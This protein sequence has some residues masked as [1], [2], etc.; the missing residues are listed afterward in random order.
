MPAPFFRR[1]MMKFVPSGTRSE[2]M[3]HR[4]NRVCPVESAGSLDNRLRRWVQNPRTILKP[5]IREGMTVVDVGCG[6][7]FFTIEVADMVGKPGT[8]IACD[9]QDGMLK[10]LR[11][12]IQGTEL[13]QRI[14]L[15]RSKDGSIGVSA[16]ADF[17]LAFYMVH[18]V[19]DQDRFLAE[20]KSM[21]KP[22][23]QLLIVEPK[24][25][26]VSKQAFDQTMR[27]AEAMGFR[28]VAEPRIFFS[29]SAVLK[30]N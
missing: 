19:P 4:N 16:E 2:N 29:R 28:V 10:K 15:H 21:L 18:E 17:V 22:S 9:I 23:G 27:K 7:G 13:D 3:I 20:V 30:K 8:V 24:Y 5:Y 25:F 14:K 11:D 6:P 1:Y 26:H 12:K